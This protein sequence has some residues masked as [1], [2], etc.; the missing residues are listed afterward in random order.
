MVDPD[1]EELEMIWEKGEELV[2]K[3]RDLMAGLKQRI[4]FTMAQKK[5]ER[6]A[7]EKQRTQQAAAGEEQKKGW[8]Q[9]ELSKWEQEE[10][11]MLAQIEYD[12][13]NQEEK[14]ILARASPR[15]APPKG[16]LGNVLS[17]QAQRFLGKIETAQEERKEQQRRTQFV[18][19][20]VEQKKHEKDE[21]LRRE[22]E[23]KQR[24]E[25]LQEM[26]R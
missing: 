20:K 7:K 4:S 21:K 10:Q 19:E 12:R 25:R 2:G 5:D 17:K 22:R 26:E 1:E 14:H 13:L 24:Q 9:Q 23:E 16:I 15:V 11:E 18:K 3:A 8:S 6:L